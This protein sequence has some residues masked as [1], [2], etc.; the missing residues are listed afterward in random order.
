MLNSIYENSLVCDEVR[1]SSKR[2]PSNITE[3]FP[4]LNNGVLLNVEQSEF[5]L[6][7]S[8]FASLIMSDSDFKR[9]NY[10][11][12][13]TDLFH[14]WN[15]SLHNLNNQEWSELLTVYLSEIDI[16]NASFL[17][18]NDDTEIMFYHT[19]N[20]KNNK[21]NIFIIVK[22]GEKYNSIYLTDSD[23]REIIFDDII[24]RII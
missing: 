23:K 22:D 20:S 21:E 9:L 18:I 5:N 14:L 2:I 24:S 8:V 10:H 1:F 12:I 4:K 3:R 11:E 19:E 16:K 7:N 17:F 6:L 15:K 13:L